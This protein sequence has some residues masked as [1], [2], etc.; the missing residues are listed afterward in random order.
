[1]K[2]TKNLVYLVMI[3]VVQTCISDDRVASIKYSL[4]QF[5]HYVDYYGAIRNDKTATIRSVEELVQEWSTKYL[6]KTEFVT[7]EM[8]N[9]WKNA[10]YVPVGDKY[11]HVKEAKEMENVASVMAYLAAE[12][13]IYGLDVTKFKPCVGRINK[14]SKDNRMLRIFDG[15]VTIDT[16]RKQA[17]KS[18]QVE[19]GK[20]D[21]EL[22]NLMKPLEDIHKKEFQRWISKN[23][24]E[25][26]RLKKMDDDLEHNLKLQAK[27]DEA[28]FAARAAEQRAAAAEAAANA[29]AN[30]ARAAAWEARNAG[31]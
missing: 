5:G 25:Y 26:A 29:A 18:Y 21:A 14:M 13:Q 19:M 28:T 2:T 6:D 11:K 30:A 15:G 3:I 23:P 27:V 8:V 20:I 7:R 31:W 24:Q 22:R 16:Y 10:N 12:Y 9:A 17:Q 4:P 1:M